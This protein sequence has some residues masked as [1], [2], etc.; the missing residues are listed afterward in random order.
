MIRSIMGMAIAATALLA[1]PSG[2][3][4]GTFT[5]L[6]VDR[7]ENRIVVRDPGSSEPR[8]VDLGSTSSIARPGAPPSGASPIDRLTI[9]DLRPGDQIR[10]HGSMQ[11]DHLQARRIEI[12]SA[13]SG[14][15]SAMRGV[16]APPPGAP[17][18][19]AP[20]A[21]DPPVQRDVDPGP[22]EEIERDAGSDRDLGSGTVID[23]GTRA[24]KSRSGGAPAAD[25]DDLE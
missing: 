5:I 17:S 24:G 2:A 20:G 4:E 19:M 6:R 14:P 1:T 12:Q 7:A 15:G 18:E 9:D 22:G 16:G 23:P 8:I 25:P 3:Q 10:V 13:P 21:G 11:G